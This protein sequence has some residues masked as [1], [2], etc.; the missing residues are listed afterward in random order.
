MDYDRICRQ[1]M[2]ANKRVTH[3]IATNAMVKYGEFNFII[4]RKEPQDGQNKPNA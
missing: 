3:I 1:L 2:T 4:K